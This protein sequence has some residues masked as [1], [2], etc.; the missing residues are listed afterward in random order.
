MSRLGQLE[1]L[2]LQGLTHQTAPRARWEQILAANR[3]AKAAESAT[4]HP[5]ASAARG[6]SK[7]QHFQKHGRLVRYLTALARVRRREDN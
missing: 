3:K 5:R 7:L 6:Q 4:R 2:L 1:E